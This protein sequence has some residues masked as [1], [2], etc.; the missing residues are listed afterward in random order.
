M[1]TLTITGEDGREGGLSLAEANW[2]DIDGVGDAD[3][4]GCTRGDEGLCEVRST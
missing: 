2:A 1:E 3:I 4:G